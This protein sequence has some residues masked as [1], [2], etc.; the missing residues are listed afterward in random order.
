MAQCPKQF[1]SARMLYCHGACGDDWLDDQAGCQ[2]SDAD[3]FCKLRLCDGNAFAVDYSVG[4]A[5]NDPGFSCNGHGTNY[6]N[7]FGI[8]DVHFD[9]DILGTHINWG[10]RTNIN[11]V[12]GN[13]TCKTLGN[14]CFQLQ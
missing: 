14:G 8:T 10:R 13:V 2:K 9:E 4:K 12:V 7:W 5:S 3:A 11:P 6:G 1:S